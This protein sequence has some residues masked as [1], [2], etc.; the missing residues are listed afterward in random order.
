ML[1]PPPLPPLILAP[2][3]HKGFGSYSAPHWLGRCY[4]ARFHDGRS[5]G[6]PLSRT[7]NL[8][9]VRAVFLLLDRVQLLLGAP[10]PGGQS[11]LAARLPAPITSCSL[12][13]FMHDRHSMSLLLPT[14]VDSPS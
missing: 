4:N 8:C 11:D 2:L 10:A 3:R 14:D 13:T 9:E 6:A 1:T 5:V 7:R 12:C